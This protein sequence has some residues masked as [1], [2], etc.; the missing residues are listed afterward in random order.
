TR[1]RHGARARGRREQGKQRDRGDGEEGDEGTNGGGGALHGGVPTGV[2]RGRA[3]E[4]ATFLENLPGSGKEHP[5][6]VAGAEAPRGGR[7]TR[8]GCAPSWSGV[9]TRRN[10]SS[11]RG[12][13]PVRRHR[14][15][16]SS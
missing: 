2:H 8:R 5:S 11:G 10:G 7:V 4:S 3:C 9:P 14:R 6:G 1:R 16:S 15:R 13:P 12:S